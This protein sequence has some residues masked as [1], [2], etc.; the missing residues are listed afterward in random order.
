LRLLL[1]R[2]MNSTGSAPLSTLLICGG[3]ASSGRRAC[4]RATRSRT[5]LAADSRSRSAVNSMLICALSSR[6]IEMSLSMPSMPEI[7]FSST[8]VMRV[9]ITLEFAPR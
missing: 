3:S 5:S 2:M 7:S 9:S 1:V 6:L 4:T 8:C